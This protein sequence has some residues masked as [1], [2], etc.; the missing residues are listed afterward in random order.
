MQ[1]LYTPPYSGMHINSM[2]CRLNPASTQERIG[3]PISQSLLPVNLCTCLSRL[4]RISTAETGGVSYE[5]P[6]KRVEKGPSGR[7]SP[8]LETD[9]LPA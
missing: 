3:K 9:A 6:L 7:P 2:S 4:N 1:H 5:M 8:H